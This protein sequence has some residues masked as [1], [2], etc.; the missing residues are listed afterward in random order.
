MEITIKWLRPLTVCMALLFSASG[1]AQESMG[2]PAARAMFERAQAARREKRL[3]LA[4][5]ALR[6]AIELDPK[7]VAAHTEFI[8]ALQSLHRQQGAADGAPA[9]MEAVYQAWIDAN[10]APLHFQLVFAA[11][12][13][14]QL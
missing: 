5:E 14:Y 13:C 10:P 4:V 3:D 2:N 12:M 1:L 9:R 7:Y 6:K 11:S 8:S